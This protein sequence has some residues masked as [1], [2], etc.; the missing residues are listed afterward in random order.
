MHRNCTFRQEPECGGRKPPEAADYLHSTLLTPNKLEMLRHCTF[1]HR[2][3]N[4]GAG[5]P[6]KQ[7]VSSQHNRHIRQ[8]SG[9]APFWQRSQNV[10]AGN[11]LMQQISSQ[12]NTSNHSAMLRSCTIRQ[13]PECGGRK[14]PKAAGYLHST[15]HLLHYTNTLTHPHTITTR[16]QH[17]Q[18]PTR[19]CQQ[20]PHHLRQRHNRARCIKPT[21]HPPLPGSF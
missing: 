20:P 15:T 12:H 9:T 2:S 1:R 4:V 5:N 11:P 19:H 7:Q 13:K 14:P 8:C 21:L 17:I 10:G 6:L 16:A 3:K 18:D